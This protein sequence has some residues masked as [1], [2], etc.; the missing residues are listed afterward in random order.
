MPDVPPY[1]PGHGLLAGKV[2][3]VTAAAGT[4]I[5]FATA[6]RAVEEGATVVVSDW[7]ERRLAEAAASLGDVLAIP[8]DV[9]VEELQEW[10]R[11]RLADFK[12][13]RYIDLRPEPLPRNPQGKILKR[14]LREELAPRW[15][16]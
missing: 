14:E 13:P 2:V 1:V 10:V 15:A 12:V 9:T 16:G 6:K 4:G 7:H 3:V 11:A 8:C 5:G